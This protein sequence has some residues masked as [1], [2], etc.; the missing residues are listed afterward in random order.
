MIQGQIKPKFRPSIRSVIDTIGFA[1]TAFV[2]LLFLASGVA[3]GADLPSDKI[4]FGA[5]SPKV[6]Q[7]NI[8]HTICRRG[9]TKHV[10][11][12]TAK[13][14]L[15]IYQLYGMD[16]PHTGYCSGPDGC[17][18]DHLIPLELGGADVPANLWP[19]P[20]DGPRNAHDKD[21]L[22]NA[23]HDEVCAGTMTLDRAQDMIRRDWIEAY[24]SVFAS[25]G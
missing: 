9:Y 25:G 19:Q 3:F 2:I 11:H 17:E 21:R 1:R 22:E 14:K 13:T 15:Y 12:T 10:R 5:T 18:I 4:T 16:G 23:L 8:H 24:K 7:G 6:T 20:Y